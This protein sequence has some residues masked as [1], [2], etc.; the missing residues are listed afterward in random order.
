MAFLCCDMGPVFVCRPRQQGQGKERGTNTGQRGI[1][2]RGKT[3]ASSHLHLVDS[4]KESN[5]HSPTDLSLGPC[6]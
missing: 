6:K 3:L 5:N 4:V 1:K 2:H